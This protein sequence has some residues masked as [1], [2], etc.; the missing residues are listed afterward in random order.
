M[1]HFILYIIIYVSQDSKDLRSSNFDTIMANF[2]PICQRYTDVMAHKFYLQ[3]IWLNGTKDIWLNGTK[4]PKVIMALTSIIIKLQSMAYN[5]QTAQVC[6][7]C[8]PIC[9]CSYQYHILNIADE[10]Q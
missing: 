4:N 3:D 8:I 1:L 5:L 10:K 2:T 9:I 7:M 6:C